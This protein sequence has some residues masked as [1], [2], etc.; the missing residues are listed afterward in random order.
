[1]LADDY[2]ISPNI[3]AGMLILIL[4]DCLIALAYYF[5]FRTQD[6]VEISHARRFHV[7]LEISPIISRF[8]VMG[9]GCS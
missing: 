3:N 4:T 6:I 1:M 9:A 8:A 7:T 2:K 5:D